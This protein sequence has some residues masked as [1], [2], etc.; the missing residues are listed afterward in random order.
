MG[1]TQPPG[2]PD[3]LRASEFHRHLENRSRGAASTTQNNWLVTLSPSLRL[4]LGRFERDRRGGSELLEVVAAALR[5]GRRLLV[6]VRWDDRALPLNIFPHERLV[7]S[8]LPLHGPDGCAPEALTVLRVEP[9]WLHVPAEQPRMPADERALYSP[10]NALIW[11]LALKGMREK[12]LPEIA[13]P[14][15][16]RASAL[17]DSGGLDI[18]REWHSAAAR[19]LRESV[20][21]DEMRTWPGMDEFKCIRL[22]NALYLQASLIVSRTHPSA[23]RWMW[24]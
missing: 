4:D 12:L 24:S 3:L 17:P 5:H 19:L 8:P 6:T 11:S 18:G 20:T 15:A 13:G 16:Y 1:S 10:L 2:T 23:T 21:L 22:L 14:A 9:A 7:H